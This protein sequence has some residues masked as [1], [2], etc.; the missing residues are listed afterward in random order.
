[1]VA[2]EAYLLVRGVGNARSWAS[3]IWARAC[4]RALSGALALIGEHDR[5]ICEAL[6]DQARGAT[7]DGESQ[8]AKEKTLR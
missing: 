6:G 1:M 2:H 8:R 5:Q 7:S 4:S 3:A